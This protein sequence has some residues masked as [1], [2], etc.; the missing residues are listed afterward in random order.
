MPVLQAE[1]VGE[2]G[3][4]VELAAADMNLALGG[5]AE[6]DDAWVQTMN[7]GAQGHQVQS[8]SRRDLKRKTHITT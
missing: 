3:G 4:D 8:A 7:Q 2:V 5:L 1:A 6:G